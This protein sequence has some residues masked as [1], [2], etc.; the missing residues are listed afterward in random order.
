MSEQEKPLITPEVVNSPPPQPADSKQG[1]DLRVL[2]AKFEYES[3]SGPLPHPEMLAQY[4]QVSPGISKLI[5][6][7]MKGEADHRHHMEKGLLQIEAD[8]SKRE[9]SLF[10]RGQLF[11]FLIVVVALSLSTVLL[12]YGKKTEGWILAGGGLLPLALIF[13][14]LPNKAE[15]EQGQEQKPMAAPP[16]KHQKRGKRQK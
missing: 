12:L 13:L 2:A 11:A 3:F 6:E 4:E 7:C 10:S 5:C 8:S 15:P 9:S 16:A 1:Q 14:R